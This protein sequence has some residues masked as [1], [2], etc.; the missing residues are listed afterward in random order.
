[1]VIVGRIGPGDAAA[2]CER[3]QALLGDRHAAVV[4]CD[5]AALTHVDLAT[6]E[7]LARLRLAA[8][9]V[10]GSVWLRHASLELQEL[11]ALVGLRNVVPCWPGLRL[12]AR[13]KTEDREE[14]G[15]V[16]EERDP[17]DPTA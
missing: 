9:R 10:G 16:E 17:A 3:V 8:R 2:L 7:A 13:G 12:E 4:V 6:V 15:G 1:M 14:P 11:L 5:V